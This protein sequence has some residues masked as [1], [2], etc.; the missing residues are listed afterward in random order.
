MSA[1]S[2]VALGFDGLT[3]RQPH[4]LGRAIQGHDEMLQKVHAKQPVH[5]GRVRE[6]LR[7]GHREA[8][9]RHLPHGD[10]GELHGQTRHRPQPSGK[11]AAV[12]VARWRVPL[13]CPLSGLSIKFLNVLIV[14]F[15]L[16]PC[17]GLCKSPM[18]RFTV[19]M[20]LGGPSKYFLT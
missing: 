19:M 7:D 4:L 10:G 3:Q 1:L 15:H 11:R 2:E 6:Q 17:I 16:G 5:R 9:H 18:H 20:T 13:K 8:L 14:S 12:A